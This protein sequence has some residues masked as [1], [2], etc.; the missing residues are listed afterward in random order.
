MFVYIY[1]EDS[2]FFTSPCRPPP[3]PPP[4]PSMSRFCQALAVYSPPTDGVIAP[5]S[6]STAAA[7]VASRLTALEA[8][9]AAVIR[10]LNDLAGEGVSVFFVFIFVL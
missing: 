4:T 7:A 10:S 5:V 1:A 8:D 2:S 3:R 9:H 6:N